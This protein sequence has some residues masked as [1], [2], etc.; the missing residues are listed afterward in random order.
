MRRLGQRAPLSF[1]VYDCAFDAHG[2]YWITASLGGMARFRG[3]RWERMFAAAGGAFVPKSMLAD[4]RGR[5][6]VHWND[7]TLSA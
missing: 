6:F 4:A 5:L 1:T 2:D 7:R 3:G